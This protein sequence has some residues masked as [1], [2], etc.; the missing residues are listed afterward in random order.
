MKK[1]GQDS[2]DRIVG[3]VVTQA[4]NTFATTNMN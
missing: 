2:A 1:I 4:K 3:V